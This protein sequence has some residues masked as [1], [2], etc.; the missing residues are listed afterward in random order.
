MIIYNK[1]W[2]RN[3]LLVELVE[4]EHQDGQ[5]TD[6][7]FRNIKAKYPVGFYS[8]NIFIRTGL[9]LLTL[10]ISLFSG[11]F[12][13]M[14]LMSE[15]VP[16]YGWLL[17]LGTLN[18]IVLEVMVQK[19]FHYRSG[20]DDALLWIFSGF[21]V[22]A[23][24][25]AISTNHADNYIAIS[26]FIFL[27][28]L[29]LSIRFADM[30][31]SLAAYLSCFSLVFFAWQKLGVLGTATMP[32]LLMIFSGIIYWLVKRTVNNS[33]TAF[34]ANTITI[35]QIASLLT[36]YIA[37]NYFIVKELGD[38]LSGFTSQSVPFGWFFWALTIAIPFIYIAFGVKQKDVILLRTGLILITVAALT[39]RTYYHLIPIELTLIICGTIALGVSYFLTKYLRTPKYG[40]TYQELSHDNLM[41]QLKVE[42]LI[43]SESFAETSAPQVDKGTSFGGGQFGGGGAS[44]NY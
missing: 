40:F 9:F 39:F 17:F 22:G 33:K 19:N 43:I 15:M 30:L 21:W 20:V 37:G 10:V 5:I 32:F 11:G 34:Y 4:K 31:M 24:I 29:F 18:Y 3:L 16:S 42:S 44:S 1:T 7:E 8:P 35:L 2:L 26:A 12:L 27:L 13:S 41:D 14:I 28:S 23:F 38:M 25:L 6:T 36:L